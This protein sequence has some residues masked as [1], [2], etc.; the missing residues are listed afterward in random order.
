MALT[1]E[2]LLADQARVFADF[3]TE[4]IAI[5]GITYEC[6]VLNQAK[7]ND[8]GDGGRVDSVNLRVAIKRQ[9]MPDATIPEQ[10][11]PATYAGLT[12][13]IGA[14]EQDDANSSIYLT[15]ENPTLR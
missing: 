11:T 4:S 6:L 2:Q 5:A 3:P 9:D 12:L 1:N 15:L 14:V 13:R 7:G 8:F 10:G